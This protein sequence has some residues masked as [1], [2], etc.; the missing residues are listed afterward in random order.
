MAARRS[1]EGNRKKSAF[2]YAGDGAKHITCLNVGVPSHTPLLQNAVAPF[3]RALQDSTLRAPS[4]PVI[5]SVDASWVRDRARAVET[6]SQ[7]LAHT[8][9][10]A[11]CL[12]A[13]VERGCHVCLELGPGRALSRMMIER[14]PHV[15]ARSVEEFRSLRAAAEWVAER[16]DRL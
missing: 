4:I 14:H 6:L 15:H 16:V 11:S 13:L 10:W 9:E 2:L 7:Q 5:A 12:D 8:V 3:Q 1:L